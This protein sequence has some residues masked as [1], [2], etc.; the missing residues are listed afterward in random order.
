MV[1]RFKNFTIYNITSLLVCLGFFSCNTFDNI[2]GRYMYGSDFLQ[3]YEVLYMYPDSTYL[4]YYWGHR[5]REL[6][7][8]GIWIADADSKSIELRSTLPDL[9]HIP[10]D[11][12]EECTD[13]DGI[14]I[15]FD[16]PYNWDIEERPN[17]LEWEIT[18]D[19]NK[20]MM[21]QDTLWLNQ[22]TAESLSLA[23]VCPEPIRDRLWPPFE[24]YEIKTVVYDVKNSGCNKFTIVLPPYAITQKDDRII[25]V[26]IYQAEPLNKTIYWKEL[27]KYK[28]YK[29]IKKI[30]D[31]R[32]LD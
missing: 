10:I 24:N 11:V 16:R 19:S 21:E 28:N 6:C 32:F 12:I 17:F 1:N 14:T 30:G 15:I 18:V 8:S 20:L 3:V 29:E 27:K 13:S 5:F 2:P 22:N 7:D 31:L 25:R 4:Q 9:M 26:N 23:A